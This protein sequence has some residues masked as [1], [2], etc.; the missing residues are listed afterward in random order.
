[1]DSCVS[2]VDSFSAAYE[3][4]IKL[5]VQSLVAIALTHEPSQ[6]PTLCSL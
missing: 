2:R 1:M 5:R 3:S 6:K 4:E